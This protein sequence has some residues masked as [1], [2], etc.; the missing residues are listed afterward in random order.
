MSADE[1]GNVT[2]WLT[3]L[4]MDEIGILAIEVEKVLE[5]AKNQSWDGENFGKRLEAEW[6]G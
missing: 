6:T 5:H 4:G 3:M 1:D 2:H